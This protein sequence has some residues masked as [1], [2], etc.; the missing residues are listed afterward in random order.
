VCFSGRYASYM[1]CP[2]LYI[3]NNIVHVPLENYAG[4][5]EIMLV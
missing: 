2:I 3:A 4:R 5:K 1:I